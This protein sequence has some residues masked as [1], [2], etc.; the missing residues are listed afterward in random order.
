MRACQI[1]NHNAYYRYVAFNPD[2]E[3]EWLKLLDLLLNNETSFFRHP[4]SFEALTGHVL[5]RLMQEKEKYGVNTITMWSVGCSTGQEVYSLAIAFLEMIAASFPVNTSQRQMWR[6]KITGSDLSQ[7]VLDKARRGRYRPYEVRRLPD[8]Y[9]QQYMTV[10]ESGWGGRSFYQ[11]I[12]QVRALVQ[13]GPVNLHDPASYRVPA[14]DIIFCQ[15][16]LIYFKPESRIEI[17]RWL[18]QR[19]NPGGYLFLAPAEVIGLKLPDLQ[20]VR[21]KEA[22]I[23]QRTL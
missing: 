17:I 5:P 12:D 1:W 15:N 2:G 8:P 19:L 23:Y 21:L 4:P 22:L 16:V 13:F 18:C 10:L 20:P 3:D 9:R 14:Q 7:R 11:V 6:V